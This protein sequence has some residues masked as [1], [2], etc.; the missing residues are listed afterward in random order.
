MMKRKV[1]KLISPRGNG[2]PNG[3]S[4]DESQI[5]EADKHADEPGEQSDKPWDARSAGNHRPALTVLTAAQPTAASILAQ[6]G[7]Q[8]LQFFIPSIDQSPPFGSASGSPQASFDH[9]DNFEASIR[10]QR[11]GVEDQLGRELTDREASHIREV[12]G[13]IK[14]TVHAQLDEHTRQLD[15]HTRQLDLNLSTHFTRAYKHQDSRPDAA[16]EQ[17]DLRTQARP[18]GGEEKR[19]EEK[20]EKTKEEQA[21]SLLRDPSLTLLAFLMLFWTVTSAMVHS[22]RLTGGAYGPYVNGGYN[23]LGSVAV[24]DS[25]TSFWTMALAMVWLGTSA[26]LHWGAGHGQ[27]MVEWLVFL[28]GW[29]PF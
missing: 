2:K 19:T 29:W 11:R 22:Q 23:G 4:S 14:S 18:T 10:D 21:D 27:E 17:G 24:F 28:A 16:L 9:T 5:K 7:S 8:W 20:E 25:W 15:E 1:S 6:W 13:D 12:L 26:V 3:K